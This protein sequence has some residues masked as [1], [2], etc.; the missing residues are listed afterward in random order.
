MM[1]DPSASTY[2]HTSAD[3]SRYHPWAIASPLS[4]FML[5]IVALSLNH[6]TSYHIWTR[7]YVVRPIC[8][9]LYP[10]VSRRQPISPLGHCISPLMLHVKDS[11]IQ[12]EPLDVLP[13]LGH[14][15]SS[16]TSL[17]SLIPIHQQTS[18]DITLDL[19]FPPF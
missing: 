6:L 7:Y 14:L 8:F 9:H 12:L 13:N 3:V 17:L 15:L 16:W 19:L 1:L 10:Y 11:G 18:A 2:T 5:K 4:C